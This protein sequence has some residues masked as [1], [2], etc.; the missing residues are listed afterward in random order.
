MNDGEDSKIIRSSINLFNQANDDNKKII[1]SVKTEIEKLDKIGE[2]I[3][4]KID[5]LRSKTSIDTIEILHLRSNL[6]DVI[7][8][9]IELIEDFSK[10]QQKREILVESFIKKTLKTS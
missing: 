2:K 3:N 6:H 7:K 10:H 9:R 8:K 4:K 5:L 1:E